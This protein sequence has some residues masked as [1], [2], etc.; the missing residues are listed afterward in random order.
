M[1]KGLVGRS[2]GFPCDS[3]FFFFF[4]LFVSKACSI[5]LGDLV[6]H[7]TEARESLSV[8]GAVE[9]KASVDHCPFH[10]LESLLSCFIQGVEVFRNLGVK[11]SLQL[12]EV[13]FDFFSADSREGTFFSELPQDSRSNLLDGFEFLPQL[14]WFLMTSRQFVRPDRHLVEKGGDGKEVLAII[15]ERDRIGTSSEG[16]VRVGVEMDAFG[17][18][19]FDVALDGIVV[20]NDGVVECQSFVGV[21]D[22]CWLLE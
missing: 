20:L 6:Q 15:F 7:S 3:S 4:W 1:S 10:V 5:S 22:C 13:L 12:C 21:H 8:G 16:E 9:A 2:F 14:C 17:G 11:E 18:F 19:V